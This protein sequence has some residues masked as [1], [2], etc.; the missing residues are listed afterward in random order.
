M[1]IGPLD[2]RAGIFDQILTFVAQKIVDIN[3]ETTIRNRFGAGLAEAKA[4][5]RVFPRQSG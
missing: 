3:E 5:L 4:R 2:L 1:F